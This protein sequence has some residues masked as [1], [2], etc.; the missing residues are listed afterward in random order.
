VFLYVVS[1]EFG[2][3]REDD[4]HVVDAVLVFALKVRVTEVHFDHVEVFEHQVWILRSADLAL[5]MFFS[6]MR[7][8]VVE[9]E[10]A[11][12]TKLMSTMLPGITDGR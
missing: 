7:L 9:V 1:F 12:V 3:G 10:E 2:F 4:E 5:M 6:D 8:E 11:L